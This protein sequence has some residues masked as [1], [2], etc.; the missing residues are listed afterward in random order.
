[1]MNRTI[2]PLLGFAAIAAL[3]LT[4]ACSTTATTTKSPDVTVAIKDSLK[5][6]GLKDVAVSQDVDKGVVTLKGSVATEADKARAESLARSAAGNQ[7]VGNEIAVLPPG[8]ESVAKAVNSDLD[9]G[10]AKNLDAALLQNKMHDQVKYEV[11]SGVVTLK[12]E[13][14]S[15]ALRADAQ[16]VALSV[17]NVK[18]V[19]NKLDVKNQK[20]SSSD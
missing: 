4:Q 9:D 19:V 8:A 20:A 1:M 16:R 18:Q 15:Q 14:N 17:P 10:I 7:V 13:V 2:R 3:A 12:G 11:K 5:T 6:A